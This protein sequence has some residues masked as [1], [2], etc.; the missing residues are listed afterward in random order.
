[1]LTCRYFKVGQPWL[2]LG[3]SLEIAPGS[4]L[5]NDVTPVKCS[6]MFVLLVWLVTP[7]PVKLNKFK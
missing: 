3:C 1:M 7:L 4:R 5:T 2:A 6:H